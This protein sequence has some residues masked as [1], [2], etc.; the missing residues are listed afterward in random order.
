MYKPHVKIAEEPRVC[1]FSG[2]LSKV[3]G[4]QKYL[5]LVSES[6]TGKS[7]LNWWRLIS[8]YNI[9]TNQIKSK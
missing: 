7:S 8:T 2:N 3:V 1:M 4:T 5:I 6:S 9:S